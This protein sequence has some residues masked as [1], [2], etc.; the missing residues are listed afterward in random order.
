MSDFL[1]TNQQRAIRALEQA[2]GDNLERAK[3]SFRGM[4]AEQMKEP[5]GMS[6]K[7]RMEIL[8]EY[9]EH[10]ADIERT[11]EWVKGARSK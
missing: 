11:I 9:T 2:R 5:F 10:V 4:T 6:G 3:A 1:N 8:D 7:T